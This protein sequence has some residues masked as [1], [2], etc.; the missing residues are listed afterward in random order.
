VKKDSASFLQKDLGDIV[1]EK[2]I[3][4]DQFVNTH[5]SSLMVTVLV[6]VNKKNVEKFRENYMSWLLNFYKEDE[7]K[8]QQRTR[9]MLKNNHNGEEKSAEEVDQIVEEEYQAELKKHQ[10]MMQ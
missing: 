5:G 6:V 7:E 3:S 2:K 9:A 1:Y 10:K 4:K 8:W